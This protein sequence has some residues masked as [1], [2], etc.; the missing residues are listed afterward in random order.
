MRQDDLGWRTSR[1]RLTMAWKA[2]QSEII[3]AGFETLTHHDASRSDDQAA[4]WQNS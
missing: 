3:S 2:A 1:S 4:A